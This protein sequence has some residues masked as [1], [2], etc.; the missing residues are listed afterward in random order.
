[1]AQY[2][3]DGKGCFPLPARP[4]AGLFSYACAGGDVQVE[5]KYFD[6]SVVWPVLLG[7]S[8]YD[9]NIRNG[10][11]A[12]RNYSWTDPWLNSYL[13]P[14]SFV[15]RPEY[16]DVATRGVLPDQLA[17]TRVD[18]VVFSAQKVMITESCRLHREDLSWEEA[19]GAQLPCAA[20][21]D[22][23]GGTPAPSTRMPTA[24]FPNDPG[25]QYDSVNGAG[26]NA[27]F[28]CTPGGVRGRD[29]R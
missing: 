7:D 17:A 18:E 5:A 10:A 13:Y 29:V 6:I 11:F 26:W 23:H 22:G 20:F 15:A 8:Y 4:L 21:V 2:A 27:P 9:G 19:R 16:W 14:F 25:L 3:G 1:M 28:L 12:G 24:P